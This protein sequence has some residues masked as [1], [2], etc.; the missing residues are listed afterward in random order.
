MTT[1]AERVNR[2][3]DERGMS[4]ADLARKTG[5]TTS[6]IAYLV[7]GKTKDPR[8]SSVIALAKA[9]DVPLSYLADTK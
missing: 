5:M 8:L 1:F 3:M 6:N 7:G 9:L 4:Q 2:I